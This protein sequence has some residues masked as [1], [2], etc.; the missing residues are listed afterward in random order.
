MDLEGGACSAQGLMAAPSARMTSCGTSNVT[1]TGIHL[2]CSA[3][4]VC[5]LLSSLGTAAEG[6]ETQ[7][8]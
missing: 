4:A 6:G 1:T 8:M 7:K 5:N 3:E 2:K